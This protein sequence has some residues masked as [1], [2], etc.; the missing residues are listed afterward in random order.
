MNSIKN[1]YTINQV[2]ILS[3]IKSHTLRIW[4]K[5]YGI[6]EPKRTETNIR[7]FT[8]DD[9]KKILNISYLNKAGIKISKI[10]KMSDDDIFTAVVVNY[11]SNNNAEEIVEALCIDIFNY[12]L[13]SFKEKTTNYRRE[14]SFE[15]LIKS[16]IYPLFDRIGIMWQTNLIVPAQEHLFSNYIRQVICAEINTITQKPNKEKILLFLRENEYHE[17]GLLIYNFILL[18]KGYEVFYLG[19]SVPFDDLKDVIDKIEPKVVITSFLAY[20][21]VDSFNEYVK[22]LGIISPN[23]NIYLSGNIAFLEENKSNHNYKVING[24]EELNEIF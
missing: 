7:Y 16:I 5:R 11:E 23:S 22:Q 10:A 9:L 18:K 17:L 8:E 3:G 15:K 14:N 13:Y 6:I 2:E 12:D 1:T 4:E 24:I 21:E 19:Q 20:L